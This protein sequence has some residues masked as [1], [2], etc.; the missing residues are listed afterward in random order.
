VFIAGMAAIL[1][2]EAFELFHVV[3]FALV[4]CGVLLMTL[5]PTPKP[6]AASH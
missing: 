4:I 6:R 2:G 1:L 3:A 5:G